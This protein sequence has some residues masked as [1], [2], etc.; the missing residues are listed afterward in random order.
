ME[1]EY[2]WEMPDE[3]VRARL[4]AVLCERGWLDSPQQIHM[5]A[6]YFDTPDRYVYHMHGGLRRRIENDA[7]VCCL[8]LAVEGDDGYRTRREYE[9][10]ADDIR[11]GLKLLKGSG[12]PVSVC[13]ELLARELLP[14]C[15]TDFNREEYDFR[16]GEF[17]AKL[18]F[19][20][21]HM[22][23]QT[24]QAAISEVEFEYVSGAEDAFHSCARQLEELCGLVV[25]PKSK[26]ARAASL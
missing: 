4:L 2:K 6:C 23:R 19:D 11:E 14:L 1:I 9:V 5:R 3:D 10:E 7:S 25:Q 24:R 17:D 13:D 20:V 26:L 12:A 21:G 8:K 18:A 15:E 16:D 22:S